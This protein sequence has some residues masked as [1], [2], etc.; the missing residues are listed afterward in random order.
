MAGKGI[1]KV[2]DDKGRVLIPRQL[3]AAAGMQHGDII[4]LAV[5]KGVVTAQKV[6]LIEVGDQ[7]P[8]AVEAYVF[9]AVKTMEKQT[10]LSLAA[11]LISLL[12]ENSKE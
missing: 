6:D 5:Q 8:Q 1:Y 2:L 7:S 10:L 3:R 9:S 4:K 12:E 11:R